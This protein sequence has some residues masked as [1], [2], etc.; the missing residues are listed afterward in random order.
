MDLLRLEKESNDINICSLTLT[1]LDINS[2]FVCKGPVHKLLSQLAIRFEHRNSWSADNESQ[3]KKR[4]RF[5]PCPAYILNLRCPRSLYVLSFEPSKTY[6][7]FKVVSWFFSYDSYIILLVI[8][9]LCCIIVFLMS[10]N[11]FC[12]VQD[13]L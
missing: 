8:L 11:D 12:M 7:E 6:V 4:G 9:I 10:I 13:W 1:W 3:N 5:Q 2:Q